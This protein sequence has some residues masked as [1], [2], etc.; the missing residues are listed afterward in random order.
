MP[1][2]GFGM[3]LLN[4]AKRRKVARRPRR[5]AKKNPP[6]PAR[7]ARKVGKSRWHH[8]RGT[9]VYNP[10]M[11]KRRRKARRNPSRKRRAVRRRRVRASLPNPMKTRRRKS[12]RSARRNPAR[13]SRRASR[14]RSYSFRNPMP[15]AVTEVFNGENLKLAGGALVYTTGA[16]IILNK[17]LASSMAASG[18]LPGMKPGAVSPIG[19]T[20]W[21]AGIGILTVMATKNKF[22]KF[23]EGVALGTVIVCGS[24]L[25]K[26][27]KI[28]DTL[29]GAGLGRYLS[30]RGGM[31]SYTPGVSSTFTGPG[32]AFI[33][34]GAPRARGGFGT[35]LT[36]ASARAMV[37]NVPNFAA[38]N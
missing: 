2:P 19:L 9:F 15:G 20:L 6:A 34:G 31:G 36:P 35:A 32:S 17:L 38:A 4:P 1:A 33:G 22:P 30:P 37:S 13:R 25:I 21:K 11:S 27:S 12:R 28:L 24:D 26:Q 3:Y 29:P 23:A 10:T 14:R 7:I 5:V 8:K 16:S 18:S